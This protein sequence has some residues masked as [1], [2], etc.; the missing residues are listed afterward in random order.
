[1]KFWERVHRC[2]HR[3]Q[4]LSRDYYVSISC[5]TPYCQGHESHCLKCGVYIGECLCMSNNGMSGWPYKRWARSLKPKQEA[6]P[7]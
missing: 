4:D 5:M 6:M 3:D 2:K 1:M 7:V